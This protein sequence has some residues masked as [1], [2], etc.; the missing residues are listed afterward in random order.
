[1]L[2]L[3]AARKIDDAVGSCPA[4]LGLDLGRLFDG[5]SGSI[6]KYNIVNPIGHY[7]SA[8]LAC[9]EKSGQDRPVNDRVVPSFGHSAISPSGH[10]GRF[11]PDGVPRDAIPRLAPGAALIV[12]MLFSVGLWSLIWLAVSALAAMRPW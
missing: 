6:G 10:P 1:M 3:L 8:A 7:G 4:S 5:S 2:N 9:P 11:H 12:A